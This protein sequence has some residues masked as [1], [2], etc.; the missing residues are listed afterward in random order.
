MIWTYT[1]KQEIHHG[2]PSISRRKSKLLCSNDPKS[3]TKF[4]ARLSWWGNHSIC[5][6]LFCTA[7]KEELL[8][9]LS[10][11]SNHVSPVN[12]SLVQRGL[13]WR[14]SSRMRYCLGNEKMWSGS[15]SYRR[16]FT[17]VP[18]SVPCKVVTAFLKTNKVTSL[19]WGPKQYAY[20]LADRSGMCDLISLIFCAGWRAETNPRWDSRKKTHLS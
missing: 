10:I 1:R 18:K 17:K 15:A 3:V 11:V 4:K 7:C 9:K 13:S 20:I 14:R 5:E 8:L 19:P 12:M 2:P 6:K 16:D